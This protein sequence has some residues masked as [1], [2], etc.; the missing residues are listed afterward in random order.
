MSL[1][2]TFSLGVFRYSH[3]VRSLGLGSL[4]SRDLSVPGPGRG[5]HY[6]QPGT[7]SGPRLQVQLLTH[8]QI[9]PMH[10]GLIM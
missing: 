8:T 9:S 10:C 5:L 6:V 3:V 7:G 2:R 1:K 4:C